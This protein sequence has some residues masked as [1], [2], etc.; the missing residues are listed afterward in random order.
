MNRPP[1]KLVG[2]LMAGLKILR[3]LN[4]LRGPVGVSQ[5]AREL[6]LNPSTA[7]N[8][9]RTLVHE[10][11]VVFDPAGKTY[12]PGPGLVDLIGGGLERSAEFRLIRPHLRRLAD[13]HAVTALLWHRGED[14]RMVLIDLAE[15]AEAVRVHMAIGQRLPPYGGSLGRCLAAHE[16]LSKAALKRRFGKLR[17]QSAPG[18]EDYYRQVR[19]AR[20][21]GY[22]VDS[23]NFTLGV[24]TVSALVL[25]SAGQAVMAISGVGFSAALTGDALHG[26]AVDIRERAAEA[27]RALGGSALGVAS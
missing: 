8:L 25:G 4:Q 7:Y 9:L 13:D 19:Q 10:R 24:T 21:D 18:F 27:S 22:A 23:G 15:T 12:A 1:D 2:A 11:L 17:W 14:D 26:L 6:S 20:Q 16:G 3:Y 5:V